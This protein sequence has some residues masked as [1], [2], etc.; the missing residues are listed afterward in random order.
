MIA[1]PSFRSYVSSGDHFIPFLLFTVQFC[2]DKFFSACLC[3]KPSLPSLL[4]L[5][6]RFYSVSATSRYGLQPWQGCW[7]PACKQQENWIRSV[8]R[9]QTTW[10]REERNLNVSLVNALTRCELE[11]RD[12]T[13]TTEPRSKG[14]QLGVGEWAGV[15]RW[16]HGGEVAAFAPE[17][18]LNSCSGVE[19]SRDSG[20][21]KVWR[22][23]NPGPF[24]MG[25]P[26]Q[27]L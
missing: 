18:G 7:R 19:R 23:W 14:P 22:C 2:S 15:F 11:T 3:L 13:L 17:P 8:F 4:H 25:S 27:P 1:I 16:D 26:P 20:D 21:E 5:K 9:G 12:S 10:T 6:D 24:R